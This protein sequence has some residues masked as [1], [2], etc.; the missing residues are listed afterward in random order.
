MNTRGTQSD[1]CRNGPVFSQSLLLARIYIN[2]ALNS[3]LIRGVRRW[4]RI[5]VATPLAA[6]PLMADTRLSWGVAC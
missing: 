2:L 4:R 5:R 3:S 6:L 1:D